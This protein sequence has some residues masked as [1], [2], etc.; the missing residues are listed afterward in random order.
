MTV[1]RAPIT[2]GITVTFMFHCF[3]NSLARSKYLSFFSI[4]FNFI[5]WSAETAKSTIWQVLFSCWI[6][7]GLV[8]QPRLG[9][10]FI[11]PNPRDVCVSHSSERILDCAYTICSYD[12]I[13][14]SCTILSGLPYPPSCVYSYILSV[15]VCC[16]RLWCD[17]S[18]RPYHQITN[19]CCF[20]ASYLFLLCNFDNFFHLKF[21]V[22]FFATHSGYSTSAGKCT[23]SK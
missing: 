10:A 15:L 9:D 4:S 11:T 23:D 17:W 7:L 13:S 12:Q 20:V 2:I 14:I 19:I 6:L 16:I 3:F 22:A 5:L 1:T 8:N 21:L 18:F